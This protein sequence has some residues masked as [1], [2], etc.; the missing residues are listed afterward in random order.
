M[1]VS[2]VHAG[3]GATNRLRVVTVGHVATLYVNGEKFKDMRGQPPADGQQIGVI[4]SSSK[5][6]V[7][8]YAFDNLKITARGN[9]AELILAKSRRHRSPR[10]D[11]E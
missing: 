2:S 11:R 10:R 3:D 6:G 4:G 9:L 7:A 5:K 1:N 8:S